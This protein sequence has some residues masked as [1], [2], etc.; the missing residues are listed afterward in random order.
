MPVL[1]EQKLVKS[2]MYVNTHRSFRHFLPR[3][4]CMDVLYAGFAGAK[5]GHNNSELPIR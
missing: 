1:Q 4:I 3:L 2:L 5:I